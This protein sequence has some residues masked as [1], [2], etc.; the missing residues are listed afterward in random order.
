MK[1]KFIATETSFEG[2]PG[3]M[4]TQLEG[5]KEITTQFVS[6]AGYAMFCRAIGTNPIIQ[7]Q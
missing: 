2:E 6:A 1:Y 3:Y 5:G 4:V 7:D